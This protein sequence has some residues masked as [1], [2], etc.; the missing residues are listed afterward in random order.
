M[1]KTNYDRECQILLNILHKPENISKGKVKS[2]IFNDD[3]NL[4]L[5]NIIEDHYKANREIS[6]EA[7]LS[8]KTLAKKYKKRIEEVVKNFKYLNNTESI[9][10]EI[11]EEMIRG[12]ASRTLS[13]GA[14]DLE[15]GKPV[16][17]TIN[18]MQN[19]LYKYSTYMDYKEVE[20]ASDIVDRVLRTKKVYKKIPYPSLEFVQTSGHDLVII[21]GRPSMGK[22]QPLHSKIM[23]PNSDGFIRMGNIQV[24]DT[25]Y[26]DYGKHQKVLGV[27][28]Q[29]K[30]EVVE[31]TLEDGR[32]CETTLDHLFSIRC[33]DKDCTTT[34]DNIIELIDSG[35]KVYIPVTLPVETEG[36]DFDMEDLAKKILFENIE[37][38][39]K[40][41]DESPLQKHELLYNIQEMMRDNNMVY[42]PSEHN[43]MIFRELF[44]MMGIKFELINGMI[45]FDNWTSEYNWCKISDVE[46]IDDCE[47]QCIWVSSPGNLYLTN[48]YIVTHNTCFAIEL[49]YE[50]PK[51]DII[52]F[53]SLEMVSDQIIARKISSFAKV[54]HE[55]VKRGLSD[56]EVEFNDIEI[57]RIKKAGAKIKKYENIYIIDEINTI[58]DVENIIEGFNFKQNVSAA[59]IDH[60]HLMSGG[61]GENDNIRLGDISKRL[62]M[63]AKRTH[64]DI[65]PLA[66]LSRNL[67]M[68]ENKRPV[69]ADLRGSGGFEQ[70][71]D[72]ILFVYRDYIYNN[73]SSSEDLEI[74]CTKNRNGAIGT[75]HMKI[76]LPYQRVTDKKQKKKQKTPQQKGENKSGDKDD[77]SSQK[78]VV[79]K[80]SF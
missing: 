8:K 41:I 22:A 5:F 33:N 64:T 4:K 49:M 14:L 45:N 71:A 46:Y 26:D 42:F 66:Q 62:K 59:F 24:G 79:G 53:L 60:I 28:P 40:V 73:E 12:S 78:D 35:N 58:E 43:I 31:I 50:M 10:L 30:K 15:S 32:K 19:K 69:N 54:D 20:K 17:E 68:R 77:I 57:D 55:R 23:A 9:V 56:E 2:F 80:Y 39:I 7:Y 36:E 34:I 44:Y 18:H 13:I 51:D 63:L 1:Y 11:Q 67:E 37:I 61:K 65:F 25:I 76:E 47:C 27:F 16:M 52:L 6:P 3:V 74:I 21:G 48:D 29:G 75:A 38:D 72:V 70:D